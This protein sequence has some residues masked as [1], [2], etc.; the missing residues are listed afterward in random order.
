MTKHTNMHTN[1]TET[2]PYEFL[3]SVGKAPSDRRVRGLLGF[4]VAS[5]L[6]SG[7]AAK[8]APV[9]TPVAT[10]QV[11]TAEK[12]PIQL[13][14]TS[15]AVLYPREQSAIIPK[16]LSPVE[17][18]Y[19]ERGSHVKAGQLLVQLEN[20]D[21]TG[22]HLKSEGGYQQANA[23][24]QMQLQKVGQD[25]KLAKETR[26]AAQKVFDSREILY[27]QGAVAAKDVADARISLTQAQNQYDLAQKKVDLKVAEGQLNAAKGDTA[28]AAAQLGYTRITSPINGVVTD[29]PFYPGETPAP[30]TP[31][32]TVMDLSQIIARAH[33]SQVEAA[34]LKYGDPATISVPGQSPD[35]KG[36][37]TMVSPAL[38]PNSSTVEVW[39]QAANPGGR[40]RAGSSARVTMVGKT[41]PKAV[42]IPD[43][44]LL[45]AP[46]GATSVITLDSSNVP[47]KT[48][49]TTGIR[50]GV[51]V[52]VT[53]GL[54]GGE[55][56][57]TVGVFELDKED[58]DV[59][60]QTKIQIQAP[61]KAEE[62][63]GQ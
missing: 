27:K 22:A 9:A 3:K 1:R 44:A 2:L 45:T 63:E 17:K 36:K 47:H 53:K 31:L 62:G 25:L 54:Q 55:R 16:V 18:F 30:G 61:A 50:D 10:V 5:L 34:Q 49:V 12:E 6:L 11:A 7:C 52:Q 40:L 35:V 41:V 38:D 43:A 60:A 37:V 57:V 8:Q 15:D 46:D 21:L 59:L 39:V 51:N 23:T 19:V 58:P 20:Q 29:R 42:V 4:I 33:I 13:K 26:D 48:P 24:Y 56:V 28:S 32:I 14:I